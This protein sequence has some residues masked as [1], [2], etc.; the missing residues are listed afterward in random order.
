MFGFTIRDLLW[1][2]VVVVVGAAALFSPLKRENS[3]Q[4][5]PRHMPEYEY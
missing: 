1:L 5:A 2:T 4:A 3:R